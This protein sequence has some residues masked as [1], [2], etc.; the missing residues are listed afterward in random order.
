M[1]KRSHSGNSGKGDTLSVM[2]MAQLGCA[3]LLA[4]MCIGIGS[5]AV[6]QISSTGF[7]QIGYDDLVARLTLQGDPVPDGAG[8]LVGMIEA[9]A[10]SDPDLLRFRPNESD[11]LLNHMTITVQGSVGDGNSGHATGVA[12]FLFGLNDNNPNNLQTV[13]LSPNLDEVYAWSTNS[14]LGGAQIRTAQNVLPATIQEDVI[15]HSWIGSFPGL[16]ALDLDVL[17]RLDLAIARD[18][19]IAVVGVNNGP[20]SSVPNLLA[21]GY[22]SIAVGKTD[23]GSSLGPTNFNGSGRSKPDIV[24]P[25]SFTSWTTPMISGASALLV[26]T[27]NANGYVTSNGRSETIKAVLLTGATKELHPA[28]ANTPTQPLDPRFGAGTLNID[29]SHRI[30]TSG[31]QEASSNSL[32]SSTGWDFDTI[33]AG[34]TPL[35]FF[36]IAMGMEAVTLSATLTW[37]LD[38]TLDGIT[39]DIDGD[40]DLDP[41]WATDLA[42]LDLRLYDVDGQTFN[43]GNVLLESISTIDNVEHLWIEGLP[44]GRYALGVTSDLTGG[45]S[46]EYALAWDG[47]LDSVVLIP[48]PATMSTLIAGLVALAY[49][50]R[51]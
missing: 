43:V 37:H 15:S 46:W 14:W 42:N 8:V 38:V 47:I 40:G 2:R 4:G 28:W 35:Y 1:P 6:A 9:D 26:E 33:T 34:S 19:T 18:D 44:A 48:T 41:T 24:A 13:S 16:P 27:A 51:G 12:K 32:V 45:D 11:S 7:T 17:Q 21:S 23:G 30:L 49:R 36:D 20:N 29:H 10:D 39:A 25:A 50:R 31:E 5:P 3:A 22:N